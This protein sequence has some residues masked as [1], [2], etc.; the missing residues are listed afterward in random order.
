[1]KQYPEIQHAIVGGTQVYAFDKYDGS[2][3]RAE[4]TRKRGF[5]KFGSRTRLLDRSERPLGEAIDLLMAKSGDELGLRFKDERWQEATAFFEFWG[6]N[7]FAGVY[8]C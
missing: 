5:W 1:M 6:K 2:N 7:S 8:D 3:I 4:W